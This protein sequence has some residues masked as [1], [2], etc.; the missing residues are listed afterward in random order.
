MHIVVAVFAVAV[1]LIGASGLLRPSALV[2][3]G[4]WFAAGPGVWGGFAARGLLAVALWIAAARSA[5]PTAF[6]VLAILSALGAVVLP[7][8]GAARLEAIVEK[9]AT[10]PPGTLRGVSALALAFGVFL[11]WSVVA[12]RAA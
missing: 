7:V 12:G 6:R 1:V 8:I 10:G 2:A 5:T 4:R 11:L 9:G 3:F